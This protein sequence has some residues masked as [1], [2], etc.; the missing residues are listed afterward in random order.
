VKVPAQTIGQKTTV[1]DRG[2]KLAWAAVIVA[3]ATGGSRVIGLAREI[4]TAGYFGVHGPMS[5]YVAAS[6]V[7]NLIRSLLA[8]AAISAAFVPVFTELL[9]KDQRER[10]YRLASSL[11]TAAWLVIGGLVAVFMLIT[12]FLLRMFGSHLVDSPTLYGLA[13]NT[14]RILFPTVIVL[15]SAGVIIGILY[16]YERF[17]VPALV[18]IFWNLGII[19]FLVAFA[20]RIH[21]YALAWGVFAGTIIEL[22][23]LLIPLRGLGFRYRPVLDWRDP[24]FRKVILLMVPITVTLGILNFNALIDQ[25]FAWRLNDRAAAQIGYAFRLFQLPQG[26]FAISIGTVL[27]PSLSRFAAKLEMDRFRETLSVGTRQIFFVTLPFATWFLVM[28]DA[29]VRLIYQRGQFDAAATQAVGYALAFFAIGMA[30]ANGN[31]MLNRG[32]QSLQKPWLPLYVSFINLGLNAVLDYILMKPLG[33]G[34]ITFSTSLVSA[35]NF[36]GLLYLMRRQVGEVDG[37]RIVT[38]VVRMLA[39]AVL[40]GLASFAAW[41]ALRGFADASLLARLAAVVAATGSG[42]VV[43]VVA[44]KLLKLEELT[45]AWRLLRRRR[46]IIEPETRA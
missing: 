27:F 29:I 15:A 26:M 32:F 2:K 4:L 24:Y 45:Q 10:A 12:P 35:F 34:G 7:P 9:A 25:V 21:I 18:P 42:A 14:A 41:T 36:F 19:S 39:C 28:P 43:Y 33:V 13:T 30:F 37:R 20:D 11:L 31:I 17:V 44:A 16:S 6:I 22:V 23:L 40:L 1:S 5:A 8:E 3:V 46:L 38:S